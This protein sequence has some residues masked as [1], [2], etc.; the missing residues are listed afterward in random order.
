MPDFFTT[1]GKNVAQALSSPDGRERLGNTLRATLDEHLHGTMARDQSL[2]RRALPTGPRYGDQDD[3]LASPL[4]ADSCMLVVQ[5]CIAGL[6]GEERDKFLEALANF[7]QTEG[8]VNG[9]EGLR[10]NNRGAL[11]RRSRSGHRTAQDSAIQALNAQ[12]FA[13]RFPMAAAIK[14]GGMGR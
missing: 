14:F 9:D 1:L 8:N 4:D 12:S 10:N 5:K 7:F 6:D 11:D 13:R 2:A 3:P